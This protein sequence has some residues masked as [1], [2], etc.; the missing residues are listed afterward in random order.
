MAVADIGVTGLQFHQTDPD[1]SAHDHLNA[2]KSIKRAQ[3]IERYIDMKG[4]R[5]LEVG[6]GYGTN[7]IAW[8]KMFNVDANGVEPGGVGFSNSFEISQALLKANGIDP[9]RVKNAVGEALPFPDESFDLVYSANVLEHTDNPIK[10]L[11]ESFRV[12]KPAGIL[13]FEM[14]NFLAYFEGHYYVVQPPLIWKFMLPMWVKYVFRRDPSFARTLRTEINPI[15]CRRA[16]R[17]FKN[18]YPLELL[19]VGEDIF[20]ERLVAPFV[21]EQETTRLKL[22]NAVRLFQRI[23]IGN[24]IGRSLTLLQAHYPIYLTVRKS[25][26]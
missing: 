8:T 2:A 14:P 22:E 16:I 7:L 15:W 5:I 25:D 26:K 3:N 13:H 9:N 24:W 20:L 21:F 10:V 23:N 18:K 11:E 17:S 4:K 19:S 1:V 12:L 6:S